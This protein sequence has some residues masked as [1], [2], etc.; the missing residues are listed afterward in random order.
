MAIISTVE[1]QVTTKHGI[2]VFINLL[3]E[4]TNISVDKIL[5]FIDAAEVQ[6]K[7]N[8]RISDAKKNFED[9]LD[10]LII[11]PKEDKF[12]EIDE[13]FKTNTDMNKD[14]FDEIKDK[15]KNLSVSVIDIKIKKVK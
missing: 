5:Y 12:D 7:L 10:E 13:Y 3:D 14:K 2:D 15:K 4:D 9:Y 1:K 6:S 8:N 11:I